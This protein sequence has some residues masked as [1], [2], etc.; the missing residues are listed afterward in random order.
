M[1]STSSRRSPSSD[2]RAAAYASYSRCQVGSPSVIT[3]VTGE[4]L[5]TSTRG[6]SCK[7]T[8]AAAVAHLCKGILPPSWLDEGR[9]GPAAHQQAEGVTASEVIRRALRELK[10]AQL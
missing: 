4:G 3:T 6:I 9:S 5:R 2:R 8:L 7:R 1:C 10:R